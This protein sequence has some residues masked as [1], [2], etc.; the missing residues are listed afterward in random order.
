MERVSW[1]PRKQKRASAPFDFFFL[2]S[3]STLSGVRLLFLS[4]VLPS[5]SEEHQNLAA[6][7]L[8]L[9]ILRF[10]LFFAIKR[11]GKNGK[12]TEK[13]QP[14]HSLPLVLL[15]VAIPPR[16]FLGVLLGAHQRAVQPVHVREVVPVVVAVG[17]VVDRVVSGA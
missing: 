14:P 13:T 2:S 9:L 17:G 7:G 5:L 6:K 16:F 12:K 4:L 10:V 1:L 3:S 15:P 8:Q 11:M